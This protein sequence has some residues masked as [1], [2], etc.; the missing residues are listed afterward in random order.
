MTNYIYVRAIVMLHHFLERGNIGNL[1]R[2]DYIYVRVIVMLHEFLES[3]KIGNLGRGVG[4][5]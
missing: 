3:G 1:G 2:G 4:N 5:D